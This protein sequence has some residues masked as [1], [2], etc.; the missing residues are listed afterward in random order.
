MKSFRY[1]VASSIWSEHP[2]SARTV[3]P[4]LKGLTERHPREEV[5]HDVVVRDSMQEELSGRTEE[6]A[7]DCG[8]HPA[9]IRPG[10]VTIPWNGGVCVVEVRD[11][12]EPVTDEH[13]RYA[14]VSHHSTDAKGLASA[15]SE[16]RHDEDTNIR[17]QYGLRLVAYKRR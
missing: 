15:P 6:V 8:C 11:H 9:G 16:I 17:K 10:P 4:E 7:V 2:V 12:Y 5:M 3:A 13:P 1:S 14:V